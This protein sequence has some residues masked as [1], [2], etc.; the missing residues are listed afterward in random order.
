MDREQ[1]YSG[2]VQC[3]ELAV[4]LRGRTFTLSCGDQR[5][6]N[7][8][9]RIATGDNRVITAGEA[10]RRRLHERLDEFLDHMRA[11]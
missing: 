10:H 1:F 8:G 6:L 9:T 7:D 3:A 11:D 2:D 5:W 4:S